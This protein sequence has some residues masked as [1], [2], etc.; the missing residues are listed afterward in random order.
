MGIL[1]NSTTGKQ[2]VLK[3]LHV[4]GRHRRHADT[5]LSAADASLLHATLRWSDPQWL[6]SD[7]SRNGCF[8]NGYALKK[9]H[10][11]PLA[12]HD[13]IRFGALDGTRWKLVDATAPGDQL[14]PL[15]PEFDVI[16]LGSYHALPDDLAPQVCLYRSPTGHWVKES[17]D[18]TVTLRE[19]DFVHVGQHAW[20]LSCVGELQNTLDPHGATQGAQLTLRCSLDEE[21]V[22]LTLVNGSRSVDMGERAHHYLLLLLAR[23]RLRDGVA[24]FDTHAQGWMD[25]EALM[26]MLGMDRVHLNIQVFRLRKQFE[27]AAAQGL[28][29]Q[30]FIERRRGSVRL[31]AVSLELWRGSRLE[32]RWSPALPPP[33]PLTSVIPMKKTVSHDERAAH[34]G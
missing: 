25:L 30:D 28:I 7:Q 15:S 21:H 17:G 10:P 26:P 20:R 8:V 13:E 9:G 31:G 24:N 1:Q 23:Q 14:I 32:G 18:E 29:G 3:P 12:P 11:T 5:V 19:G 22:Y 27:D 6:L 2:H 34:P 4:V 16:T 33:P